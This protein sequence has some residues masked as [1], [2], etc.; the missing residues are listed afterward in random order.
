MVYYGSRYSRRCYTKY[1][2]ARRP[3]YYGN[4]YDGNYVGNYYGNY[5]DGNY[6][7]G[8]YDGN[9]YGNYYGGY[10]YDG[11]GSLYS[12]YPSYYY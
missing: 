3:N 7:D 12:R 11:L 4:N 9:Y 6:Y 8:N 5:Y 1:S 2:H 10:P